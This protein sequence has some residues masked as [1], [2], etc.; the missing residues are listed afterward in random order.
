M[1]KENE[2]YASLSLWYSASFA[3]DS[4][5]QA[6]YEEGYFQHDVG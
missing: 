4:C 5:V 6:V 2:E 1:K 3:F